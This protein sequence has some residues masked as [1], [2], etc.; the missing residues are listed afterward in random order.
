MNS[1]N[2]DSSSSSDEGEFMYPSTNPA[3][4]EFM[5]HPR[6]RRKT[7]R[8][9]KE[10]AALGIFGSESED[11][12]PKRRL[13]GKGVGFM[14][15]GATKEEVEDDEDEQ[16]DSNYRMRATPLG[17]GFVPS[18]AQHPVL[19]PGLLSE[20]AP[21]PKI[22]RPS[23]NSPAASFRQ[24]RLGKGSSAQSA[25]TNPNSFAAKMMAKMGYVEG[26]GLGTSGQ[27][28]IN[29]IETKLRPQGAGLGAVR[30]K[31]EQAKEEAKREAIRR[32]EV[33]EDSS[34]EERKRKRRQKKERGIGEGSGT[35]TPGGG[36]TKPKLKYRT[37]AEIEAAADGLEVPNVLKSII[38]A[39]GKEPKLLTSTSG[40]MTPTEV[41]ST[42]ESE[43][44]KIAKRARR[45]LEAFAEEWNGLRERKKYIE[46]QESQLSQEIDAEEEDFRKRKGVTGAVRSLQ[47]L[48]LNDD[49]STSDSEGLKRQWEEIVG[50]LE[51]LEVD[52]HDKIEDYGLLEVAVGAIHPLFRIEMESWEPIEDPNHLVS[53]LYRLRTILGIKPP[54]KLDSLALQN[55][56]HNGTHHSKSTSPYETMIYTLWFPKIRTAITNDW[57]VHDPSPLITLIEAWKD[58]LP[59]FI[60][61]N[62]IDQLIV[63]KLTTAVNDWNPRISHKKK[64]Q[65]LPPHVWLFPWLQYLD[66]HH[67]DPKSSTGL[68]ADMK[69]KFRIVIDTWDLTKGLIPGLENWREV[70]RSELDNVLIRHLLPRLSLHLQNEFTIDPSDQDLTPLEQVLT[71]TDF[72]KPSTISALLISEFFPKWHNI[73]HIWLTSS[74]NYE[75]IS[76]WFSWWKVRFPELLNNLP[77][78]TSE[79]ERGLEMIN[80]ALDLGPAAATSL[81]PPPLGPTRSLDASNTQTPL[82]SSTSTP[83]HPTQPSVIEET[84]FKDVLEAWCAEE[85]LL[86]LSLKEA[87]SQT[88]L[89]IFRITASANG[90]GGV[91]VYLKGDVVWAQDKKDKTLWQPLGLGEWL[92]ERAEGK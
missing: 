66:E 69:R 41:V 88:G 4:D 9:A 43:A 14:K 37:A 47:R 73:L 17:K 32:G 34:E 42:S 49:K 48:E 16:E 53:Y 6:K 39:T 57:D 11:E 74:P 5:E 83:K 10:S 1:F 72:F 31:T 29:P 79:W 40:L 38:D 54:G 27:G 82:P 7:G 18:S 70:L 86:L 67:V 91:L 75:E 64:H 87:H 15:A 13:R 19:K 35:S 45:D 2:M 71:W 65:P 25:A 90:R 59:P 21:T 55:G 26:Q 80:L 30:E 68:L 60:Y 12:R 36:K 52:Y 76:Q 85:D 51:T 28:I 84:T 44:M 20:E 63:Q 77:S 58:I 89:P 50:R 23:F 61:T 56:Y 33:L 92:V 78:M 62:V 22:V 81:P 46:L 3:T 8:D 24:N